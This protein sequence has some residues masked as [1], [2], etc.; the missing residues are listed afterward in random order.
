M[1]SC[2]DYISKKK[3][4]LSIKPQIKRYW[5]I[6]IVV[7]RRPSSKTYEYDTVK[8]MSKENVEEANK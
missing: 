4:F 2:L 1:G 5:I 3:N 8:G 7:I 6:Y